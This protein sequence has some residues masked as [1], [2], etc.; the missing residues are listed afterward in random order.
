K[1][2]APAWE[3]EPP[4]PEQGELQMAGAPGRGGFGMGMMLAPQMMSQAD[5]DGDERLTKAEFAALADTWFDKLDPDKTG[6]VSREQFIERFGDVLPPPQGVGPPRGG[7]RRGGERPDGQQ[8][9][10]GQPRPEAEQAS[11]REQRPPGEARSD[12]Q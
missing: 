5:K 4:K 1:T 3:V 7:P 10:D 8:R 2:G 12:E 6:K 11:D 9:A